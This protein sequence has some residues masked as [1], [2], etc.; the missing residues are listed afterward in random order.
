MTI[1]PSDGDHRPPPDRPGD[2]APRPNYARRRLLALL[3]VLAAVA[4]LV[5]GG[6]SL[7][8]SVTEPASAAGPTMKATRSTGTATTPAP[9]PSVPT[10]AV[11]V[12]APTPSTAG[13]RGAPGPSG[14]TTMVRTMR[15][16]FESMRPK[17]I[18]AGPGGLL[19]AQN[20]MYRHSVTVFRPDG[21]LLKTIPDSVD[22]ADHGITGHPGTSQGAP[23]EV[24]FTPDGRHAY[25]SNYSM[26]GAGWGPE[27]LDACR[28]GDGTDTST[29]YKISTETFTIEKVIPVGSVPKYVAVTPDGRTVLVTNWCSWDLSVIDTATDTETA[30]IPLGGTY[31]RGI[32]V[33][34]D[35]RTAY[36]ALMGS[37]RLVTVDLATKTVAAFAQPGD[38]PR[39][40]VISPDAKY[41]YVSNNRSANVVKI[42]RA[43]GAILGAAHTGD[44][45]RSVAISSDGQAIYVVNYAAGSMS[46]VRTSDMTVL[47]TVPTDGEP[48]GIT[49]EPTTKSV[50]VAC[51]IGSL[52][53][54]DD[55]RKAA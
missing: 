28:A 1:G 50:W 43:T 5:R 3:A 33:S 36:V 52:F 18:V 23:V 21:A 9:G 35:S 7:A 27:G 14:E 2:R 4:L 24:A 54:F 29:V 34:P 47:Q 37:D 13:P 30:R 44:Q 55:S 40:I 17:S 25:V 45:P 46:K 39:H 8:A 26:Y 6:M 41:L 15:L 42:D 22:L 48:I 53:V 10:Q 51:Y 31:P 16:A 49:Y 38:S 32:V 12:P 19:F 20:M 11:E